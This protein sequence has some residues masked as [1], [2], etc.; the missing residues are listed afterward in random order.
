LAAEF[1][2]TLRD[3]EAR[4]YDKVNEDSPDKRSIHEE[5]NVEKGMIEHN[6][7]SD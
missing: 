2:D 6:N 7:M 1:A 4:K 3:D 5:K